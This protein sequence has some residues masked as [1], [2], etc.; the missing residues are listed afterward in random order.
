MKDKRAIAFFVPFV[1]LLL[2]YLLVLPPWASAQDP[3]G[4]FEVKRVVDGDT[5]VLADGRRVRYLG[6]NT[7]ERGEPFWREAR[8]Y[9]E[10]KVR[11]KLIT[12]E[13]GQVKEDTY[14]RTLA[15]C[16]VG[17]E[18]VNAQL[19]KAG[20]A[21][22]FVLEPITYYNHFRRPGQRV[23]GSGGEADSRGH[24]RSRHCMPMPKGTTGK[25]STGST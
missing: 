4:T 24:S 10:R 1:L 14:G 23:W 22:L 13:F 11:G 7:P 18:M 16:S 3:G 25:I 17:G 20:L 15:Y 21:H 8:D 2:G 9:N 19:L 12:L 6:I 5:I